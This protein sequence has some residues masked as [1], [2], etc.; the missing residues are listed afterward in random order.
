[1]KRSEG[2]MLASEALQAKTA[3]DVAKRLDKW[4]DEHACGLGFYLEGAQAED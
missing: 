2:K 1:M 4:L 3:Q